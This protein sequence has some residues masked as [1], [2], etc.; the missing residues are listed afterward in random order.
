MKRILAAAV[1]LWSAAASAAG[2]PAECK[3]VVKG[4]AY[5][6]GQCQFE[7]DRDGSFRLFADTYFVYVTV[8][9]A[10]AEATWNGDPAN[11]HADA[12]LGTLTRKGACWENAGAKICAHAFSAQRQAAAIAAQP[13]GDMISPDWPGASQSC[14]TPHGGR[15]TAGAAL[16]LSA[17]CPATSANVFL[18]KDG[19]IMIDRRPSLCVGISRGAHRATVELQK[20]AEAATKWTSRATAGAPATI[21]SSEGDCW[22]IP[23]IADEGARFPVAVEATPCADS[24][25]R[26][27]KFFFS[28]D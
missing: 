25:T 16:E 18:R 21:E 24:K 20:C 13:H 4:K 22:T 17:R 23:A 15:W 11:S 8:A 3:L 1:L 26:P 14:V 2:R 28:A 12:P 6:D 19:A 5:I 9:G 27:L 10:T 7:A